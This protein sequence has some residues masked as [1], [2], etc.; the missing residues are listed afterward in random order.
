[1]R[2]ARINSRNRCLNGVALGALF[3]TMSTPAF[4]QETPTAPTPAPAAAPEPQTAPDT[5]KASSGGSDIA[6]T[7]SRVVREGYNAPTPTTVIGAAQIQAAAPAQISDYINELPALVGSQTPRAATTSAAATVGANL[8]NLR[9]L[10]ANRTLVLLNGH[11][12]AP[13]TLTGN[14]DVNLLPQAIVQRVDIVTGGASAAWG[15]DAV[16]GVINYVLDTK[17]TGVMGQ[18]QSGISDSGDARSI[19]ATLTVG[20]KFAGD[21]GRVLVSGEYHDD[22]A[23]DFV[24]SRD[25]FK[26]WKVI[27][28]PAYAPGNGQPMRLL[29]PDVGLSVATPGGLITSGPLANTQFDASG[30]PKPFNPGIVSGVLSYGGDGVDVSNA[31]RLASPVRS[32]TLFGRASFDITPNITAYAEAGYADVK[33]KIFARPYERDGNITI[34]NDNAYLDAATKARMAAAGVTSFSLGKIFLDWGPLVGRNDREQWRAVGGLEGKFGDGWSWDVYF[35]HGQTKFTTGDYSVN[36]ITANFNNAVDAVAN[37]AANGQIVCRST[38]TNPNNGCVPFNVFGTGKGTPA[39]LA[40]IFGQ[41]VVWSTIKQDV[42]SGSLRGNPFSTWAGP[43]SIALGAEYRRESYLATTTALDPTNAFFVGNFRGSQGHYDVKEGFFE[44]VVPLIDNVPFL[45][46]VDFNGAIRYTDYS[47]SG[48][49]VS[50]KVGAT[51]D[52]DDQLR[53]R[54]TR[55]KDIRAPNLAEL[56]QAGNNLNQTIS[57]PVLGRSYSV[58]QFA[59][60]NQNLTPEKA[61]TTAVGVVYRPGWLPGFGVSVDYYDIRI[62]DAIY[63]NTAQAV[64]NL[65]ASGSALYCSFVTRNA[66]NQ[67]TFVA[68]QPL[69]VS[70]EGTRGIDIEVNYRHR[71]GGGNLSLRGVG[72][73]VDSR[74]VTAGGITTQYAGSNANFDQNSQAVPRWRAL[75]SATYDAGSVSATVTERFIGAGKLNVAW[76]EGV[77]IDVNRVPAIAYTDLNLTFRPGGTGKGTEIYFAVQNLL[78]QAPPVAPIYGATGFLSTGTNGFLYDLIGRQFRVGARIKF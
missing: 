71:L 52:V 15:S 13:T 41:S 65:C 66:A 72:T 64:I 38:L 24:T 7:G 51:W 43:I 74:T 58:Q 34:R 76:K 22:G 4:A 32:F 63:S 68:L 47:L 18:V 67:I 59:R 11:R 56:F 61:D 17:F 5:T 6:V 23:G 35:Q 77:D 25:W 37:P 33:S 20:A 9:A 53:F 50:W 57:D 75:A 40:Y 49:V 1:M 28:N 31:I 14:I 8:Y 27:G 73:Y 21:R 12:V 29:R 26:S 62:Q 19:L 78:D 16:A 69:N 42:A 60:G 44:T 30:A 55:S 70:A 36:P 54:A 46:H 39:A 2:I 48:S 45:K 3:I 10:G